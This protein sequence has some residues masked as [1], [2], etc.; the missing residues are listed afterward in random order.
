MNTARPHI[1]ITLG[2]VAAL[3]LVTALPSWA[4]DGTPA[5]LARVGQTLGALAEPP[6]RQSRRSAGARA[7]TV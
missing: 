6:G 7:S 5:V 4:D 2:A 1:M 3:L